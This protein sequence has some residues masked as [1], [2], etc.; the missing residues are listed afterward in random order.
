MPLNPEDLQKW[1]ADPE[2]WVH[3]EEAENDQWEFELRVIFERPQSSNH[4][5]TILV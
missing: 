1:T 2:D 4:L 5:L 3:T